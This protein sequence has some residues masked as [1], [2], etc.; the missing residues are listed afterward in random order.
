M[1]TAQNVSRF[2]WQ[3]TRWPTRRFPMRMLW[4]AVALPH[5]ARHLALLHAPVNVLPPRLPCP[6]VVTV[7]DLAFARFPQVVAPLRRLY[8]MR[9]V[10][11]SARRAAAVI[12]VSH[13]TRRDLTD[14]WG[15]PP[16]RIHVA[17]PAIDPACRPIVD[18]S[19][20][21]AF[22]ARH[23]L[24]R[25]YILFLGSLEP[26]KNLETLIDAAALARD[27]GWRGVDLVLAG[28]QDWR[29]GRYVDT[30]RW[31]IQQRGLAGVVR[32]PGYVA[33][34]ERVLWLNGAAAV[35]LPSWYEGF[36]F[37]IVEARACGVPVI[38]SNAG[39]LPEVAGLLATLCAPADVAAWAEA[40]RAHP[41]ST[42]H[43]AACLAE[44]PAVQA[45]FTEQ[46]MAQATLAVYQRVLKDGNGDG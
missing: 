40:L 5:A 10:A 22:A 42:A 39:S 12:A 2:D 24:V 18:T 21:Q 4:E 11:A 27:R 6:G 3:A 26:R 23:D 25:P 44:A 16:E 43:R 41:V 31:R 34:A 37:P 35:A 15:I 19:C 8:L 33:Q 38:A 32:L 1:M 46:A 28:A 13:A 20:L 36:G 45:R 17:Y 9:A 30:L 14:L 29:G 7:H